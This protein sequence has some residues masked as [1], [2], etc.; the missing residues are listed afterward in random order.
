MVVRS[1]PK[2]P[3]TVARSVST[4]CTKFG[5]RIRFSVRSSCES[6]SWLVTRK[7]GSLRERGDNR[8]LEKC[9][10]KRVAGRKHDDERDEI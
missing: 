7:S 8:Q 3:L 6:V 9:A 1:A 4:P 2:S 10:G 5:Q